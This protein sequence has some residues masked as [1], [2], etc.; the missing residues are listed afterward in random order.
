MFEKQETMICTICGTAGKPKKETRG[1]FAI[2]II[3]W[4]CMVLP[5]LLYSIWRASSKYDVCKYC[6][7]KNIVPINSP[8]GQELLVKF[9]PK[10]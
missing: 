1:S 9:R 8:V 10:E 2:E 5:G 6:G 4:L 3:L 7:N